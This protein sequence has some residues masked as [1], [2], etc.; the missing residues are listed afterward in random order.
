[1]VEEVRGVAK[2]TRHKASCN[3]CIPVPSSDSVKK[4]ALYVGMLPSHTRSS[5]H[6]LLHWTVMMT[7]DPDFYLCAAVVSTV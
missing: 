3:I 4:S 5:L 2:T 7:C 1:M 6:L